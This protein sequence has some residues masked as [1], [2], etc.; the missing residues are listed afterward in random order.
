MRISDWSS[1]VCSSD[2]AEPRPHL[3][4][5][6]RRG[7]KADPAARLQRPAHQL[8]HTFDRY[9]HAARKR[10]R[11]AP[12]LRIVGEAIVLHQRKAGL[13][14]VSSAKPL[15]GCIGF[16]PR[17]CG[18]VVQRITEAKA[19]RRSPPRAKEGDQRFQVILR[20]EARPGIIAQRS[21]E[22]TA[23]PLFAARADRT[24]P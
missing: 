3:L 21:E 24:D 2:L 6:G 4:P 19:D 8:L 12:R 7:G 10:P 5:F 14:A 1:D 11:D 15:V 13:D 17:R 20:P 22:H 18:T 16:I 9:T 23:L